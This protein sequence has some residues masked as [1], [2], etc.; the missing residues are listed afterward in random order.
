M[1]SILLSG[2]LLDESKVESFEASQEETKAMLKLASLAGKL[3][4]VLLGGGILPR[5]ETNIGIDGKFLVANGVAFEENAFD[6][7]IGSVKKEDQCG[8]FLT[9]AK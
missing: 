5:N 2:E 6:C 3:D 7:S 1:R 8:M 4:L 9:S